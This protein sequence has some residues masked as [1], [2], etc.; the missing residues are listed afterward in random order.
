MFRD[1]ADAGRQLG[2]RLRD[3]PPDDLVVL[4]LPRGGV[5]VAAEVADALDVPL[6]VIIVRKVGVPFHS[7]LAMG[8]I[9]E[10]GVRVVN[11]DVVR[12]LR[13]G[14]ADFAAV[15]ARER[16]ELARRAQAYRGD[17]PRLDLTGRIALIV[18][19]GIAT[20]STVRA[21][22]Q[23]ARAHGAARVIVAAPVAPPSAAGELGGVADGVVILATPPSFHAIGQFY[24]DFGPTSDRE[25]AAL[26]ARGRAGAPIADPDSPPLAARDGDVTIP[27]DRVGLEGHLTI[28]S[29]ACGVVLFAH[30]SGSSRHSPR[31]Q[32]VADVLN[33]AGIGTLLFDL[34]TPSEAEWRQ[35]VFDI[36]SLQGR[37]VL[38]TRWLATALR[39]A[40]PALGY[41]GASTGAAAALWAAT[42]PDVDISAVV[43]RGGRPDLA[44]A[45]LGAVRAPTLLIVGGNDEVVLELNR[46]ARARMT[47]PT[48]LR[49]VPGAS[50]LFEER[51]TLQVAAELARD[52]FLEH[53]TGRNHMCRAL[54]AG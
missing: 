13:V 53:L 25:V 21:A 29:G 46:D 19:D 37:L 20:G 51:G 49:V 14:E 26:L 36:E 35:N 28:P 1:R 40:G 4:G 48:A 3:L 42:D 33:R 23:V 39:P 18:D 43:S 27:L 45:R 8:A 41:F 38:A 44:G 11:D 6:D 31:N 15:E 9:G 34:L 32:Y 24:D 47:C 17:R 54:D 30:G 50:H 22:C 12:S 52:W 7:E 2:E 10:D 5:P 16:V